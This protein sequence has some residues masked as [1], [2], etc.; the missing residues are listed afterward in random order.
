MKKSTK[1]YDSMKDVAQATEENGDLLPV[2][3]LD[4]RQA[5]D[6]DRLGVRVLRWIA[7]GLDG[8]GLGYFPQWVLD[9]E[10]NET[11]RAHDIVRVY[12]KGTPLGKVIDAVLNPTNRGDEMLR[13]SGGGDAASTLD[14]IRE[15]LA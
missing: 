5:L 8:E 9:G 14:R 1:K 7:D 3:L 15:L 6:Y 12:R 11:P 13:Q 4:L 2:S 10:Q